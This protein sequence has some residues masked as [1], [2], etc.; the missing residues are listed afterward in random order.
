MRTW[1]RAESEVACGHCG[2]RILAG[3]PLQVLHVEGVRPAFFRCTGCATEPAPELPAVN[4]TTPKTPI[5]NLWT[6]LTPA[7]FTPLLPLREPGEEG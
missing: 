6:R 2:G 7:G 5:A 3:T 4:P 1:R